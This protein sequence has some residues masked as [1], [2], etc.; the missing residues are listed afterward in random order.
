MTPTDYVGVPLHAQ[1]GSVRAFALIDVEDVEEITRH[2]WSWSRGRAMRISDKKPILM[3][4]QLL[5]LERD[6]PRVVDHING[7]PLDNRK[8]NLRPC[9][10]GENLQNRQAGH[11]SSKHLG[12]S[13]SKSRRCW[14]AFGST[15]GDNRFVFLGHFHD[16]KEA[17]RV[18]AE[19]R[20][21]N[22]PFSKEARTAA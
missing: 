1:D 8:A 7:D 5:R 4:R 12:V 11:G 6:D 19:W 10:Q 2:R 20:A 16:E 15:L 21:A 17:A 18:A 14:V 22:L 13:W 9:T 3:H